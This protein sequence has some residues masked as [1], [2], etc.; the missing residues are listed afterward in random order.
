MIDKRKRWPMRVRNP[1]EGRI[2]EPPAEP[3]QSCGFFLSAHG[4]AP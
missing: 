1:R 2:F 4:F 3:D